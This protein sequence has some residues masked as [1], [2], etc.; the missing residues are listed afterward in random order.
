MK[1]YV[2]LAG[3]IEGHSDESI[4][5][6][7][8]VVK[9][10]LN[11][12]IIGVT[13]YRGEEVTPDYSLEVAKKIEQKNLLDTHSCDL[14]LAYLPRSLV[15]NRPSIGTIFEIAWGRI[16]QKPVIVVS[17]DPVTVKHPLVRSASTIFTNRM[18]HNTSSNYTN[19]TSIELLHEAIDYINILFGEYV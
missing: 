4:V 6:W 7:R 8:Q 14:I 12:G 10:R 13:P 5:N 1:K 15:E 2:Y 16:L 11:S 17:D 19:H 18:M 9:N 3:P